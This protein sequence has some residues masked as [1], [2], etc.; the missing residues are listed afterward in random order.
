MHA[1]FMGTVIGLWGIAKKHSPYFQGSQVHQDR[2]PKPY[3]II[4]NEIF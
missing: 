4:T 3:T 1:L 2:I